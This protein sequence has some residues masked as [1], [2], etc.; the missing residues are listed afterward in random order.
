[1][2]ALKSYSVQTPTRRQVGTAVENRD[3]SISLR[4]HEVPVPFTGTLLLRLDAAA[5]HVRPPAPSS[6]PR[7]PRLPDP[8][9]KEPSALERSI[10]RVARAIDD[11]RREATISRVSSAMASTKPLGAYVA[12]AC[13]CNGSKPG[14]EPLG[15]LKVKSRTCA[16]LNDGRNHG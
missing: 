7:P 9:T 3:G 12:I 4:L 6:P 13:D 14:H 5:L 10:S 2:T 1:M 16:V 15:D 11:Q 8:N